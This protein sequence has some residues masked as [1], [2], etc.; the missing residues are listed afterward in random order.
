[1]TLA[2]GSMTSASRAGKLSSGE[3]R[4]P[5]IVV[6]RSHLCRRIQSQLR[7]QMA[8]GLIKPRQEERLSPGFLSR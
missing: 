4:F 2:K 7:L 3:M 5:F 1:M 8:T 6:Q